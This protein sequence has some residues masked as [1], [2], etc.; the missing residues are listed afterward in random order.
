MQYKVIKAFQDIDGF[1]Q[2]GDVIEVS[3]WREVKLRQARII[4]Q[5][6]EATVAETADVEPGEP[7][8][9]PP[10][11]ETADVEPG[12]PADEPPVAE[13]ATSKKPRDRR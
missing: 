2:P 13:T 8:D 4:G 7:A 6:V 11:A 12:E 9:E 5:V 1:K 10:V 3:G